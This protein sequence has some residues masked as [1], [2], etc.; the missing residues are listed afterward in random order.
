MLKVKSFRIT[1]D[2]GINEMLSKYRLA[3][4]A[5]LLISEGVVLL[6]FEDGEEPTPEILAA[7]HREALGEL[8]AAKDFNEHDVATCKMHIDALE[9][10][11]STKDVVESKK[12]FEDVTQQIEQFRE[13]LKTKEA[14]L[15]RIN[16]EVESR[17]NRIKTLLGA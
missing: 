1:D 7:M 3:P 13:I 12:E 16:V 5:Q 8:V 17:R 10:V 9:A 15:A 2:K 14:E 6:P 11:R 4:K